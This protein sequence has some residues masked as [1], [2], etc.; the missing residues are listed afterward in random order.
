MNVTLYGYGVVGRAHAEVMRSLG[1]TVAVIDPRY[2]MNGERHDVSVIAVPTDSKDG[3]LDTSIAAEVL[4]RAKSHSRFAVMRSTLNVGDTER[5]ESVSGLPLIFCPEFLTERT[6]YVDASSPSRVLVGVT[7]RSEDFAR[8]AW[9]LMPSAPYMRQVSARTAELVK[10]A[11]NAFYA[12]KVS[13]ANELYDAA[14]KLGLD[15]EEIR[16]A[17]VA[18]PMCG[19]THWDALHAGYR[20]FGGKCLP[21]DTAALASTG[22]FATLDAALVVNA[23]LR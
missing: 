2:S 11:S 7:K 17:L 20:G 3:K 9:L 22:D 12:L 4:T 10:L 14:G 6:A 19:A 23:R 21:K 16:S 18:E 8:E 13:Y 15:Y 5:L 1:H